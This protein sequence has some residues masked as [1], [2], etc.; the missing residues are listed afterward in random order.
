MSDM[1][2]VGEK[3]FSVDEIN[4]IA[5]AGLLFG[6]KNDPASTTLPAAQL[7]GRNHA[8]TGYGPLSGA[9]VRPQMLSAMTLPATVAAVL[10]LLRSVNYNENIEIHTGVTTEGGTNATGW[11]GNPPANGALKV[12]RQVYNFGKY[13]IKTDL[14][15]V[16]D[17]GGLKD[18]ADV[19][20]EILNMANPGE[21]FPLFPQGAFA[22]TRSDLR[23]QFWLAG[24]AALRDW[25]H[26]AI[27]GNAAL[28]STATQHGWIGEFTGL[29][30]QIKTGYTDSVT[31]VT[32]PAADSIVETF[33]VDISG[34]SADGRSFTLTMQDIA[35]ALEDRARGMGMDPDSVQWIIVMRR[36][37]FYRAAQELAVNT[38]TSRMAILDTGTAFLDPTQGAFET[39]LR[40]RFLTIMGRN[41]P[42]ILDDGV[43]QETL[44]NATYKSDI[45]FVPVSWAGRPLTYIQYF[46]MDNQYSTE[47]TDAFG[48][49]EVVRW[50]NGLWL[51]GKRDTALCIEYHLQAKARLILDFPPLAAR[52]DDVWYTYKPQT[53]NGIPGASM[54]ANGGV[55]NSLYGWVR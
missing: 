52:L 41:Y 45:Y 44:A 23:Y 35:W 13:Y 6:Q 38:A 22:D 16:A 36:E 25:S 47:Y 53:R 32:C 4:A 5:K 17:I 37:A 15:A 11:C 8:N 50:N 9:G 19:P 12:C 29:D 34:T 1:I 40:G 55:S 39:F 24:I 10:P 14:E 28:A 21:E 18:Y 54:Y 20:R 2:K 7:H 51:V 27:Q 3:E 48:L 46:P 30:S 26:V 43:P 31:G 49:S 42:V 33:N